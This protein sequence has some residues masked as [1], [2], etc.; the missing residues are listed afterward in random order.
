M[1][2]VESGVFALA[3]LATAPVFAAVTIDIDPDKP[4]AVINKKVKVL[5]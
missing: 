4:G 2:V 5:P 1:S 3:M